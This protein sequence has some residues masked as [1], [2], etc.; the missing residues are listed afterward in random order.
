MENDKT[1]S[2]KVGRG[3]L[4]DVVVYE[5]FRLHDFDWEIFGVLDLWSLMPG[6]EVVSS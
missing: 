2:Q 4:R 3:F 5:R 1:I 6:W